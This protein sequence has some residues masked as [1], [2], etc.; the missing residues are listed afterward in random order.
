MSHHNVNLGEPQLCWGDCGH[1]LS[2]KMMNNRWQHWVV[3]FQVCTGEAH[4]CSRSPKFP[5][6]FLPAMQ[7][8]CVP[9]EC[10]YSNRMIYGVPTRPK[11]KETEVLWFDELVW[12]WTAHDCPMHNT[13]LPGFGD[14]SPK[15]LS[16]QC[17]NLELPKPFR[18][19][20]IVCVKKIGQDPLYIIA[21]KSL[22][23][24]VLYYHFRGEETP[25]WG[26]L[27]ALCG[28]GADLKLLTSSN[29]IL[30]SDGPADPAHLRLPTS[31]TKTLECQKC[32]IKL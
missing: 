20:I 21:L 5:P 23:G 12:P 14:I 25:R 3:A 29:Q 1:R 15:H 27:A 32:R 30:A 10:E 13:M 19:V 31:A 26:D 24:E 6:V 16:H 11:N 22:L 28:D 4:K 17:C 8:C 7:E 18:L 9:V 2:F